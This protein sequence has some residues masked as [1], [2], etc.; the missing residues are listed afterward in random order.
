MTSKEWLMRS[1]PSIAWVESSSGSRGAGQGSSNGIVGHISELDD[2]PVD[3]AIANDNTKAE[4]RDALKET[5]A[6]AAGLLEPVRPDVGG[7][8]ARLVLAIRRNRFE[9]PLLILNGARLILMERTS[10]ISPHG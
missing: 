10:R 4:L 1:R 6:R 3:A 7:P 9:R 5:T 2:F 8:V